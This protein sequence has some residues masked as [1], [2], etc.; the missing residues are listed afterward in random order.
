M[1]Y[2]KI[3]S[4]FVITFAATS[5]LINNVFLGYSPKI[6]ENFPEYIASK[7]GNYFSQIRSIANKSPQKD[8]SNDEK[9]VVEVLKKS[10]Q[11][12]TKGVRAAQSGNV[13]Y[14]EYKLNE[15]EWVVINYILTSGK[16]ISV[17]YP[18]GTTPPPRY[19]FDK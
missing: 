4:I 17:K 2:I 12:V 15:V 5:L 19:I 10:L 11:P 13:S 9:A 16:T 7:I 1:K 8:S 3:F 6:R 14:T 18:K